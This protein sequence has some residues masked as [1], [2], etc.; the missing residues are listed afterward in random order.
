MELCFAGR[1][2]WRRWLEEN[3]DWLISAKRTE[4][5]EG[6]IQKIFKAS[7]KNERPGML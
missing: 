2:E 4:T 7:E 6:R 3:I 1:E 5:R